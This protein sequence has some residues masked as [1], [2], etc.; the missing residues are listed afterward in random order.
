M[1]IR[2]LTLRNILSFREP[3]LFELRP[4]NILIGPNASVKSDRLYRAVENILW[5]ISGHE[6]RSVG[7]RRQWKAA[8]SCLNRYWKSLINQPR[9]T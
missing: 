6:A 2:S 5:A 9:G 1:F 8:E 7:T 4:L 3:G